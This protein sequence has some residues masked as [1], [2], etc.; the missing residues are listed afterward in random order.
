MEAE[1]RPQPDAVQQQQIQALLTNVEEL[2]R[3]NEELRKTM[4]SQNAERWGTDGMIQRTDSPFTTKVLNHSLPPKFRLPQLESYDGSKDPLDHIESFKTLMLLQMTLDEV[5][6]RAFPTTLKGAA[7]V[8]INKIPPGAIVE[9]EQLSKGFVHHFIAGRRHKK[10]TGH[11]L[12]IQQAEG[13]SLRQYVTRFNKELLQVDEAEDQVILTTFQAGLLLGD[14]FFSITKSPAKTVAKLLHKAQKYMNAKDAVLAKE[15]KGKRKRDEGTNNNRDKKETRGGGQTI[16]KKKE[17][18]DRKPK[19]TNFTPL[20]MPIEQVLMQIREDPSL[21]WSKPISAPIERK[22]KS[23]Y[24]RFHQEHG[25]HTDECTL[26]KPGGNFNL[27]REVTEIHQKDGAIQEREINSVHSRLPPIKMPR[28]DEPD[29]VFLQR[30]SRGIRQPH[31]DPLVIMLKVE[32][33]N[34]HQVLIDNGSSANIIYLP[35]FQQ[36]KLDKKK[37]RPFH[38]ASGKLHRG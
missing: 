16:G 29:I 11:L 26:E 33:F 27:A 8:W 20:I 13:E 37:I 19:F 2:T 32:E 14:F 10:P 38:L 15:M 12:N 4:E 31:D 9:F 35:A 7:R 24:C 3:Q 6:C 22:D 23:K 21:Q 36:M 34:I 30:D 5:M 18:P 25:H 28:N 1:T 17:L